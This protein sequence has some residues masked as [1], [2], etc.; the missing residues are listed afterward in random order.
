MGKVDI[1]TLTME[2]YLALTHGNQASGMV[3][4]EI[5]GNVNFEIKS[6]IMREL[7]EDTFLGNQNDDAHEHVERILDIM[8]LFIIL[9]VTH[10]AV[11]LRV[12]PITLIGS[13]KI[14]VE[15]LHP[16]A[17]NTWDLLKQTF[18]QRYCPP[19]IITKQ[20]EEIHNFKQEGDETLYQAWERYNDLL[21]KCPTH[22]LN[23]HQKVNIFYKGLD[24]VTRQLLD[25]QGPIPN[26][27]SGE[28]LEDAKHVEY[29]IL[30]KN[31]RLMKTL[32]A[33][34]KLNMT[35]QTTCRGSIG[36]QDYEKSQKNQVDFVI[37]DM[38]EDVRIPIILA[39]KLLA[40]TDAEV[41]VLRLLILLEVGNEKVIFK[42]K[43][44]LNEPHIESVCAIRN[45]ES[46]T[47]DDLMKIDHDLFIY[48]SESCIKTHEFNYLLVLN[49]DVFSYEVY[50]KESHEEIDYRCHMLDQGELWEIE[51]VE[52]P[53]KE[54]DIDLSSLRTIMKILDAVLDKL[55]DDW[56]TETINDKDNLDGIVDY[57][58]LKSY[59]DFIDINDEAY[60][61]RLCKLLV[62]TYKQSSLILIE[63]V[64]VTRNMIGQG[65]S[66][67]KVRILEIGKTPKTNANIAAVRAELME[68]IDTK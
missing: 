1:N 25:S 12:F 68:E 36:S 33:L 19:S 40:T 64:E 10:D 3:K 41:D 39:R 13:T 61:E 30:T 9:G 6:Q 27:T 20:L 63:K 65:E 4:L 62:M 52:E 59:D 15:R 35:P 60:K 11:M 34:R 67:T 53:N 51:T 66:Y 37:L 32:K 44:N 42:I 8:S 28:A 46:V 29:L 17:F 14:W 31:D 21:Y 2:Q 38:V 55:D 58:E 16:G 54:R 50:V 45:E 24:T 48:N 18:I 23:I 5:R 7:R 22:D 56:F 26:K 43:N 57:L 49:P 47:D